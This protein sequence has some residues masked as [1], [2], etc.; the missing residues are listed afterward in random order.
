M[1]KHKLTGETFN[2]ETPL[3]FAKKHG[4]ELFEGCKV[5]ESK[6]QPLR[7][8]N[9]DNNIVVITNKGIRDLKFVNMLFKVTINKS[10]MPL[11]NVFRYKKSDED[12]LEG[13]EFDLSSATPDSTL[14]FTKN[15]TSGKFSMG[16]LKKK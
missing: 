6:I 10:K 12:T 7:Y 5:G 8:Q 2:Y 14:Q 3:R 1:F 9:Y 15:T 16:L 4:F 13:I 11:V